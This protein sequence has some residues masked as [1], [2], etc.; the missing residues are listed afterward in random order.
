MCNILIWCMRISQNLDLFCYSSFSK[1]NYFKI[2]KCMGFILNVFWNKIP[3]RVLYRRLQLLVHTRDKDMLC[4]P[5]KIQSVD[6]QTSKFTR[7]LGD[8]LE[9]LTQTLEGKQSQSVLLSNSYGNFVF[10]SFENYL[11]VE[12]LAWNSCQ[13]YLL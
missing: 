3:V 5:I 6:N 2:L 4:R 11:T 12:H 13:T 7:W 9:P 10:C 1:K 8:V